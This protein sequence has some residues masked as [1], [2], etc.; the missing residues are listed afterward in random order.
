MLGHL[1]Y[2]D[3]FDGS[4]S[5]DVHG[6]IMKAQSDGSLSLPIAMERFIMITGNPTNLL[7]PLLFNSLDPTFKFIRN[8]SRMFS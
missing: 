8:V 1:L 4:I 6:P 2:L 7:Q 3:K 5:Y